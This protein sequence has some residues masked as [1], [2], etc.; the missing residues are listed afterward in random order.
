[1]QKKV[2]SLMMAL[3]L[4]FMG[5]ARADVVT[6]GEGTSTSYYYPVNMYYNYSLTQQIYTADEIG[7][8][9]TI[10]S[11]SFNYIYGSSFTMQDVTLYMKNV[12]RN[13]FASNSDMEPLSENDVVWTGTFS[14]TGSGWITIT[15]DNPFVY[16]GT[17]NLLVAG[18]DGTSGYPGSSYTFQTSSTTNY[19]SIMWYSDGSSYIPEPYNTGAGY[20][21]SK[22]Y[23]QYRNN[24]QLDITPGGGAGSGEDQLH[25]KFMAGEEEVIDSLNLGVRPMGAWM[26]PF[27]FTMYS[28]GPTYTVTVLDFTPDDGMFTVEGTELPFQV[29]TGADVEL[30][31]GTNINEA[32]VIERQFVAITEGNRVAHIWPVVVEMY[33]PAIPDVVEKAYDLGTL[34]P[35]FSYEGI[36]SQITPTELHNDYTLPFPEIEEGLDAV[37][38]FTV[39]QDMV[40][41]AYVDSLAESGKVALYLQDGEELPHPMA[42][43]NYTGIQMGG[44]NAMPFETQIGEGTSTSPYFPF[45]TYYNYSIS[46]NLF[47]AAELEEAGVTTAPFTSLS[48]YATNAPG[49]NQQ[50]ISI[51]MANVTDTEVSTTSPLASGMTLVYT[52]E[53]MPAIGWNEFVL[54][55]GSFSW[56]G[57]SNLLILCQRNNGT[58][59]SSVQWQSGNPG[60]YAQS[61][62]FN[63][64]SAYDVMNTSYNMNRSNT[65]R[66]NIIMKGGNRGRNGN[67]DIVEIGDG[68]SAYYHYPVN[69]Y[70]NYSFTEQIYTAEEIGTAGTI[71]SISFDYAYSSAFS[72]PNVTMYMKNVSRSSFADSYDYEDVTTS[73]IVWTGTF[74]ASATGWVTIDLDTPFQ[75]DGTSNL[76]VAF[77][78]GTSG[79][80]GSSWTFR[81]TSTTDY[82]A[83]SGYSDSS[84]PDPYDM[85]DYYGTRHMYRNNIQLDITPGA[86]GGS[87]YTAGPV[88][89]NLPLTAG[90]YFLVTSSTD[91]DY[92]VYINADEMPCPAGDAEGFAFNP[93][94]ADNED[95]VEP[96]RVTLRWQIPDYAT[97]WRL[98]FGSTYYPEP[99]HPQTI[100][101]PEDGSWSTDMT[102][103]YT[104]TGLWNNTNYFWHVEFNNGSCEEGVSSPI[105]GFTTH[106]NIPQNL[107]AVDES[108]FTDE[109]IVLNWNAVVDRT[110]RTYFIYRDGVKVGE[111]TVNNIGTTTFTDGPLAYNMNGYTY[112][113]T[114]I[115]DEGE[116]APSNEVVV[117]VSGYSNATGINGYV[118]EQDGTTG[119]QGALVTINGTDEFG[120]A[121]TYTAT[122]G[123]NGYYN[124]RVYAGEYTNAVATLDGY[125]TTTT[126]HPLPFTVAYNA[127]ENDVNFIMDEN[128]D[129]PCAVFAEYYPDSLDP[130]SPYVKVY[131]GCG[132][133]PDAIIEDFEDF[134][135]TPFEWQ[136]GGSY[137]W[138][139]TTTN[140]YE[141]Q[142]CMKSGG[143]GVQSVTSDMSVTVDIPANG[144]MSFFG[145][146]SSEQNWDYGYFYIDGQQMGA[147]TGAGSWG[148]RKFNITE[149]THTFRWSYQKDGSVDSNDDCFYVDYVNFYF[150]P[151]P[152]GA[153]WHTYLEGEWNDALRS[154]VSDNPSFAYEYPV[155]LTSQLNG[156]TMTKTSMF[157]DV[158]TATGG[159][160]T[161]RVYK[162][163]NTPGAGTLVST[164]TVDLPLGLDQ[165]VEWDLATP[166]TVD[167][168]QSMWVVFT[169]DN[170]G[171]LGYPAGMCHDDSNSHGDW[172]DNGE[173]WMNY[174]GGVWTIRNYFSDRSG[175]SIVLGPKDWSL[176]SVV[177]DNNPL[178]SKLYQ[179]VKGENNNVTF[180]STTDNIVA[181]G[182]I[183]NTRSLSH[184]RVYRTNCYNDGPYTE[185]NTVL[186][187][188]VWVPDTVYIDVEWADLPA[189]I[190]KWGVGAVYAGNRGE[191]VESE[192]AW[193]APMAVNNG[194]LVTE[195]IVHA[196]NPDLD[197]RTTPG[198]NQNARALAEVLSDR[199]NDAYCICT[200]G[201]ADDPADHW[202]RGLIHFDLGNPASYTT[203]NSTDFQ[204]FGLDICTTDGYLYTNLNYVLYKIDVTTG[205]V[206]NETN[207]N[208][209]LRD[210][211]WDVTT[212]TMYALYSDML[213]ALDVTTG[214][215]TTIGSMGTT[216]IAMACDASGQ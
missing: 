59:N 189:G 194:N 114:A 92:T 73:D 108:V 116:S 20:N 15:L 91:A 24:I 140:P 6:I 216:M 161:C 204:T 64:G 87:N 44:S 118:W 42:D 181:G 165:W 144:M 211:A 68:T 86:A 47:L 21:G 167:G 14:A 52:G 17:S 58:Y 180:S 102:N 61:Y 69:M 122:S 104:V 99:G 95:E 170:A 157:S 183:N 74:A 200:W 18:F 107:T 171:G 203:L 110:F 30:T 71:N 1:M 12:T 81:T 49:Y 103:S 190:Y 184:Y 46:T 205:Q 163:G 106:L 4:A 39:D 129:A 7:T 141:G 173:G 210:G 182:R 195:K 31:M 192:I 117:K 9:G 212:N 66:P 147:Y 67:R 32:G 60:F 213:Y 54:N 175:R 138:T 133:T 13:S 109:Q 198:T 158:N 48:W 132:F 166:V 83:I 38:K 148:E 25:V 155:E 120:N 209:D 162:G 56:D 177:T 53:S 36:P 159:T 88:I 150:Q 19:M 100:I 197:F 89:E 72:M 135:N 112:Y 168:S 191:L 154:N 96:A 178:N 202:T 8:A 29:A 142:Y 206:V 176:S 94:P 169:V 97:G 174:G 149:G 119:I 215:V 128:F 188:T 43:N 164:T 151:E 115:Y 70:F 105:W 85:S 186:L 207:I 139:L 121:H 63:D 185:E 156:L 127:Q 75:Y 40:L 160:Y 45:Y 93:Q 193:G 98:V 124:V 41:T 123:A 101:Y 34:T 35:G 196:P 82:M 28:D 125:Q 51:W 79:Y 130:N 50:G 5:V 80:P 126:V 23:N 76:L 172:W 84:N 3:V 78:D 62:L 111:T 146:I 77:Y 199:A 214:N 26:E 57:T 208:V 145:K 37:Y 55:E 153:G 179:A 152:L 10:N 143:A 27:N 2:F 33:D 22:L 90:T 136:M 16:D 65:A 187:A 201:A 134:E 137:P 131:W 113:V 11:I